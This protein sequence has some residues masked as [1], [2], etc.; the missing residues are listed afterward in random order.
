MGKD[1]LSLILFASDKGIL[2]PK[3]NLEYFLTRNLLA[4][5]KSETLKFEIPFP[6]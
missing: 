4:M 6:S 2:I 5:Y 3:V 1:K